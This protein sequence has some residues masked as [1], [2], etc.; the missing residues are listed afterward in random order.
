LSPELLLRSQ[1]EKFVNSSSLSIAEDA[2]KSPKIALLKN[3]SV[4]T[5]M[6]LSGNALK[7]VNQLVLTLTQL[8]NHLVENLNVNVL[9]ELFVIV[10]ETVSQEINAPPTI[11]LLHSVNLGK[12][13]LF[14]IATTESA[15]KPAQ[16]KV[17]VTLTATNH[18][19]SVPKV[20][21]ET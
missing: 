4:R 7:D 21:S 18:S 20:L 5:P 6:K 19:V 12:S 8:V 16:D 1:Q 11:P 13:L 9:P 2:V 14:Q 10:E 17:T 3:S 15:N